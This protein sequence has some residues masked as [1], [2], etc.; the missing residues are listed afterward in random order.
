MITE[1]IESR[2]AALSGRL[3][4]LNTGTGAHAHVQIYGGTRPANASDAPGTP[5]L[6]AIPLANPAGAVAGG[7][8]T[9]A[10]HDTGLIMETG[11]PTWARVVNRN[12]ATVCDMNAGIAGSRPGGTNPECVLST[13]P[14]FAGG[15]VSI[16]AAVLG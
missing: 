2:E 14:L 9:L 1:T 16:T 13:T 3:G 15:Q 4:F 5:L 11:A 10:P 7:V 6:V 8:L 12:G